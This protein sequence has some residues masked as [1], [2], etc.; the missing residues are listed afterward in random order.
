[1]T[2]AVS[3]SNSS[4]LTFTISF[5]EEVDSASVSGGIS[6]SGGTL[7]SG[8]TT[9]DD[10]DYDITVTPSGQGAVSVTMTSGSATDR[11]GNVQSVDSNTDQTVYGGYRCCAF[12]ECH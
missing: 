2:A 11:A 8:P 9:S 6:I 5:D 10:M 3:H 12:M 1:M 7:A 4:P